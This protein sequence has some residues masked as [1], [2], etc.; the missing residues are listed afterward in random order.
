V[1]EFVEAE[2]TGASPGRWVSVPPQA[3][4]PDNEV[5]VVRDDRLLILPFRI[6]QRVDDAIYG[7]APLLPTDRVVVGDLPV[8]TQ[9][10]R[11]RPA[12]QAREEDAGADTAASGT[13]TTS[14]ASDTSASPPD[15]TPFGRPDTA[16]ATSNDPVVGPSGVAPDSVAGADT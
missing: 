12:R 13:D 10:M 6:Y 2:I 3:L 8:A 1:G 9:G 14:A 5:Y 15:S 7:A 4:R 16:G 11:V